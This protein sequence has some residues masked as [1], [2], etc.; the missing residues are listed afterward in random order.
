[1]DA[2]IYGIIPMAKMENCFNA[3]PPKVLR[4]PKTLSLSW[5]ASTSA[6]TLGTGINVPSRNT[7][8]I[9]RVNII[10]RLIS[11]T[12]IK[13]EKVENIRSPQYFHRQLQLLLWQL[14]RIY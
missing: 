1:M 5:E 11:P 14:R 7:T 2:V 6:F 9:K 12:R 3:P 10:F 8:N 4:I 13:L